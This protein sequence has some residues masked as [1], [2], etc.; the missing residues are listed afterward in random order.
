MMIFKNSLRLMRGPTSIGLITS[1][2]LG[3]QPLLNDRLTGDLGAA[4][5]VTRS[6][7]RGKDATTVALPYAYLDKGRFFARVDTL[8][9]KTVPLGNGYLEL[10][11]R[12]S[13]EGFKADVPALAG[14]GNRSNPVPLGLGT[15]QET[16]V[17]AFFLN[18]FHDTT[19]R[20]ALLEASYATELRWGRNVLYPQLGLER[21]SARYVNHLYG[22]SSAEAIASGFAAYAPGASVS[23]VLGL[24]VQVPVSGPW[25]LNLQ[26]RRKWLDSA[27]RDSPLVSA[28]MQDS[29]FMA[30]TA[31]FR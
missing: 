13:F 19:S 4:A 1:V 29:G 24:A 25:A 26:W 28:R 10:A 23:P 16:P 27:V 31:T 12:L 7:V 6:V 2:G 5:Y 14:I 15:Y 30:L 9:I 22:V 20:G 21:R 17:G 18:A 3:A 8:G 11:G